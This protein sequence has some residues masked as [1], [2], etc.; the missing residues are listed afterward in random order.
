MK[1]LKDN[2]IV[3]PRILLEQY[4]NLGLTSDEL[5]L[6]IYLINDSDKLF[7]PQIFSANLNLPLPKVMDLINNLTEK[8]LM[9]INVVKRGTI[10]EEKYNLDALYKKLAFLIIDG[11]KEKKDDSKSF[12]NTFEHELG[13]TLS[14][15]EYE[16]ISTWLDDDHNEEII[17]AALKEAIY[18]GVTSL[19]YID[20]I[21]YEWKKKGIKTPADVEASRKKFNTQKENPSKLFDYDWLNDKHE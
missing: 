10:R 12:Y 16:I 6:I 20:K 13:R 21:L 2:H 17:I 18:N 14:P 19:R 7:N 15:M 5:V 3:I 1:I 4:T 8:K 9:D 11:D